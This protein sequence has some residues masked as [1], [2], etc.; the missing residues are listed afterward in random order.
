MTMFGLTNLPTDNPLNRV[1]RIASAVLGLAVLAF[2]V[3][4]YVDLLGFFST[5][6]GDV[7]GLSTN[8]LLSTIS[9][10]VGLLLLAGA[11][12]GGNRSAELNFVLG[13]LFIGSGLA[14]LIVL[15]T[16]WNIFNFQMRNVIFSFVAGLLLLTFGLY[17]R[18]SGGLPSDNPYY[19]ARHGRDP[20]TGDVV[21]EEKAA[22][23]PV[24]SGTGTPA[25][26]ESDTGADLRQLE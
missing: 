16:S 10:V 6:G 15:Q 25:P 23:F 12:A 13:V 7:L 26:R 17:G 21:D 11:I 3:L 24:R 9:V 18:V 4:G 2:G 19:R 8:V 22:R 1:Y 5:S 20:E 14:N